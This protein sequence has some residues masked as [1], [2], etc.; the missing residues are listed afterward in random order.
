MKLLAPDVSLLFFFA[1]SLMHL[2][3]F[4]ILLLLTFSFSFLLLHFWSNGSSL[5]PGS[6]I[7]AKFMGMSSKMKLLPQLV[8]DLELHGLTILFCLHF[9]FS[10]INS[11]SIDFGVK[12][13]SESEKKHLFRFYHF[14]PLF[15]LK[16][17][18]KV[19]L[20]CL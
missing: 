12:F 14:L 5:S 2:H 10:G 19:S 3:L 6:S 8:V 7:R 18:N 11:F 9:I 16:L 20:F 1:F 13:S 15:L 17:W 4:F